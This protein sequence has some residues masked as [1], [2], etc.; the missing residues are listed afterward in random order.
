MIKSS[1]ILLRL[2]EAFTIYLGDS[3]HIK[4]KNK[5]FYLYYVIHSE[6]VGSAVMVRSN[7]TVLWFCEHLNNVS[8]L[9]CNS[10]KIDLHIKIAPEIIYGIMT[11]LHV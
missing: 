7:I 6:S 4:E 9:N 3:I 1:T 5:K 8:S 10:S 2:R 11:H